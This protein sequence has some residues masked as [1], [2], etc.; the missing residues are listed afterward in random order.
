M[1]LRTIVINPGECAILPD[2][3]NIVSVIEDG[4][5]VLTSTCN[6]LPAPTTYACWKFDWEKSSAGALQD[7]VF[8]SL[9][10]GDN[11]Y[12][13]PSTYNPYNNEITL[14]T[15]LY[16]SSW[17]NTDP[18]LVGIVKLGC[19]ILASSSYSLKIK[20][21][22]GLPAPTFKIT[23]PS[24]AGNHIMYLVAITDSDCTSC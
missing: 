17:I 11:T 22:S 6:D 20:I 1:A 12:N 18:Q 9:Q 8:T 15:N 19:G 10:V 7:A 5:G 24:G 4:G 16:L 3:S 13:V 14:T 23:N 21:P 2:T